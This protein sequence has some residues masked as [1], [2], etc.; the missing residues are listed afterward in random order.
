MSTLLFA[1]LVGFLSS[2][3][4]RTR[5]LSSNWIN[6]CHGNISDL[7]YVVQGSFKRIGFNRIG[8]KKTIRVQVYSLS[9]RFDWLPLFQ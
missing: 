1:I 4:H 8:A 7:I 5:L 6:V 2:V 9:H 3:I